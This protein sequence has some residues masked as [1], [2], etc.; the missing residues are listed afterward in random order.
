MAYER[1]PG[2]FSLNKNDKGDNP[3][4]PDY[5]GEGLDLNGQPIEISAWVKDGPKGK[6]LS[7]TM[8]PK[9]ERKAPTKTGGG[10]FSDMADDIPFSPIRK[11]EA[12]CR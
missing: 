6:W 3:K 8:K 10:P 12:S 5:R 9:G 7:A 11:L 2:E 4:R 1:K